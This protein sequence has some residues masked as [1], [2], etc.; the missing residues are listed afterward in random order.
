MRYTSC[1]LGNE[2]WLL[3]AAS[4]SLDTKIQEGVARSVVMRFKDVPIFYTPYISFP[5]GDERKSGLLFP[6][7]G[8]SGSNGYELEV[9]YYFN[10]APN[11]DFTLTPGMLSARGVQLAGQFRY[12]SVASHGQIDGTFLPNDAQEHGDRNYLHFVDVTDFRQGMRFDADIANVSDHNYFEDF[13]VGSDQTSVTFLERRAD[14]L[15]YDDIAQSCRTFKPSTSPPPPTSGLTRA[16]RA[17][18]PAGCGRYRTPDSSSPW[19]ARR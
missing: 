14:V 9:P 19:T 16:C 8:H 17:C 2:D 13:A 12:L 11:Y 15:Y 10:L 3:K 4:I 6:S 1:P 5:L 7:F 18:R